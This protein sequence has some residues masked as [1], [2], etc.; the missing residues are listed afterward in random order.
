MNGERERRN[1]Q[2]ERMRELKGESV[3]ES[4]SKRECEKVKDREGRVIV[5][6]GDR[7]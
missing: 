6:E 2:R 7:V 4:Q 1:R 5:R 3:T